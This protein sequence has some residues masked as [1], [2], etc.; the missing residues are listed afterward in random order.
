MG[1]FLIT[2]P[3]CLLGP[4]L[5]SSLLH[6]REPLRVDEVDLAALDVDDEHR[7][8][9]LGSAG[10]HVRVREISHPK[11]G[12]LAVLFHLRGVHAWGA[13]TGRSRPR[14]VRGTVLSRGGARCAREGSAER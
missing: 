3:S 6:E 9:A 1:L 10:A 8:Q 12:F 14:R 4:R 11:V 2:V 5:V 7:Q 13:G